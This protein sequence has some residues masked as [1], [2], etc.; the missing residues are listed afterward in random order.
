MNEQFVS[1]QFA[2]FVNE[3]TLAKLDL[4]RQTKWLNSSNIRR[5]LLSFFLPTLHSMVNRLNAQ[6]NK[7]YEKSKAKLKSCVSY[8]K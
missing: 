1:V 6:D 2:H 8:K 7:K 3:V 5:H 4:K